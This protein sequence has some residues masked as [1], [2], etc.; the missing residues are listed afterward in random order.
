MLQAGGQVK[1]TGVSPRPVKRHWTILSTRAYFILLVVGLLVPLLAFAAILLTRYYNSEIARIEEDLAHDASQLAL[2]IDRDLA[3]LLAALETLATSPTLDVEDPERFYHRALRVKNIIQADIL[4]RDLRG[5]QLAN[6]RVR[7]GT[8]LPLEPLDGDSKVVEEI[9]PYI[10]NVIIGAVARQPVYTIT[11]PVL[12]DGAVTH[13]LNLSLTTERLAKLMQRGLPPGHVGAVLDRNNVFVAR[14]R[15]HE[16]FVGQERKLEADLADLNQPD[17]LWRG[18]NIEQIPVL[19]AYST[20]AMS[21]WRVWAMIPL[22]VVLPPL[23]RT[24][25]ELVAL[26]AVLTVLALALAYVLARRVEQSV[27]RLGLAAEALGGDKPVAPLGTPLRE[28]NEVSEDLAAASAALRERA[29]QRDAAEAALRELTASLETQVEARSRELVAEMERRQQA[30]GQLKHLQKLEG[31]GQLTGGIA[32]DFN[33]ML[34][35]ILGNLRL[36]KRRLARGET[37][38]E[39]YIDGAVEGAERGATLTRRLLAFSR[40]QALGPEPIELNKLVA[41]MAEMLRR[42]IPEHVRLETVLGGGLWRV[43]ADRD[44]LESAILNLAINARD[45]MAEGGKLTIE[46]AN[47]HLD[48]IYAAMHEDVVVGQYVMIAVTDNGA[49]MPP[50]VARR[51]FDPFFTTKPPG[52]G[53]GLGLSQVYGFIKQSGGHVKIYSELG[54]GTTVRIYLPRY[55]GAEEAPREESP[56][57]ALQKA[58]GKD[59]VLVVEDSEAVRK[60]TVETLQ[61][62]GYGVLAADGAAAALRLLDAHPEITVL[63]TDVVMPDINGRKLA[64]EALRRRPDLKV[65]FTTGYTRNAIVHNGVLDP[66][67]HFIA[68]PFTPEAIAAKLREIVSP[69]AQ[70]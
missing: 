21:G 56:L 67:V 17:G 54:Q 50:E 20:S 8:P 68:K 5:Q 59:T 18:R 53:T 39:R 24:I 32:H 41:G 57:R 51:A 29:H 16:R 27:R 66:G 60:L 61:E 9:R 42:S 4:L 48:E 65:L 25:W 63:F 19:A 11:V 43:H 7:W 69:T 30:E 45:A 22:D 28:A 46:T 36:L 15:Q 58:D 64:D 55:F 13:F 14:S 37:N 1:E 2:A 38:I 31:L 62:L 3:G 47:A 26:G 40:Q 10:S 35:V 6:T 44:Q 33:N 52:Q 70:A 12:H 23:Q 49:G 34:A